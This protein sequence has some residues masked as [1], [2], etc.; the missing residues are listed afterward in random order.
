[1]VTY[2]EIFGEA[3]TDLLNDGAAVGQ[4]QGVAHRAVH[5]GDCAVLVEDEAALKVSLRRPRT[6]CVGQDSAEGRAAGCV[7]ACVLDGFVFAVF[8]AVCLI[9]M[10]SACVLCLARAR[11]VRPDVKYGI[12]S[13]TFWCGEMRRRRGQP[14]V[15]TISPRPRYGVF[16]T[17]LATRYHSGPEELLMDCMDTKCCTELP[18]L[19]VSP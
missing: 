19:P 10:R 12:V 1:M 5:A 13:R 2:V 4:W 17:D 14:Q 3:V 16:G 8:V 15:T 7:V 11:C 6:V 18:D 9:R